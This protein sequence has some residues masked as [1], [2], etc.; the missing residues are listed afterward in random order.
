[1]KKSNRF[2]GYG[3]FSKYANKLK[4]ENLMLLY[5]DFNPTMQN[6]VSSLGGF[7]FKQEIVIEIPILVSVFV[8][9]KKIKHHQRSATVKDESYLLAARVGGRKTCNHTSRWPAKLSTPSSLRCSFQ[10]QIEK[11]NLEPRRDMH[12]NLNI[13]HDLN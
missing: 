2:K 13:S 10:Y 12:L 11:K 5:L 8:S 1:M 6:V 9:C 7:T 3:H 4:Y